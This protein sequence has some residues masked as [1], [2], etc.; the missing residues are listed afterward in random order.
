MAEP[1]R[2]PIRAGMKFGGVLGFVG[3]FLLAYQNSSG[4][5]SIAI[6]GDSVFL[7]E[8][9]LICRRRDKVPKLPTW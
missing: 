2:L 7:T 8:E 3:S 5:H 1:T 6:G 4:E 9:I